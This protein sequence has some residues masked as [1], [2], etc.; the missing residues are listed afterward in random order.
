MACF[1][2]YG[3]SVADSFSEVICNSHF[4]QESLQKP[5]FVFDCEKS[6][7]E[8]LEATT[9]LGIT[10]DLRV[11]TFHVSKLVI[12]ELNQFAHT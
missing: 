9:W 5:S 7:W 1:W 11:K 4:V 10:L 8:P 2:D 3:L 6:V 12:L